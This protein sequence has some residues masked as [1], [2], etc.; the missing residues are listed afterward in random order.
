[1]RAELG[2]WATLVVFFGGIWLPL[3]QQDFLIE[4]WMKLGTFLAPVLLFA[5]LAADTK[6][7]P[8]RPALVG[9]LMLVLYIV[10]QFEE[11]WID[12][13]GVHYAFYTSINALLNGV[14]NEGQSP[15][16]ILTPLDIFVIN[17]SLVW[18]VGLLAI[19]MAPRRRFPLL[20]MNAI[21]LV[22]GVTHIVAAVGT[23]AYNPGLLTSVLLFVP[24]GLA[25]YVVSV[26]AGL[27]DRREVWVSLGWG[28]LAHAIMVGGLIA[29]RAYSLFPD[30]VYY[31]ALVLWSIVPLWLF[32]DSPAGRSP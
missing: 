10:H 22:N 19:L 20:A 3:G 11:H 14:L 17:T 1:M 18:L 16:E 5:F 13:R 12:V 8:R 25:F 30:S 24:F 29:G 23:R 9:V 15:V 26:R 31:L 21:I 28:I 2:K 32:R 27:A 7:G 6:A 4:H